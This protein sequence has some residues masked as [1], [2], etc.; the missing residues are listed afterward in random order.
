V[1]TFSSV[2]N[3][4]SIFPW[5]TGNG[6]LVWKAIGANNYVEL[7][8]AKRDVMTST[9][10]RTLFMVNAGATLSME[11]GGDV[12]WEGI[13]F[14]SP[15]KWTWEVSRATRM[16]VRECAFGGNS[17]SLPCACRL[18]TLYYWALA[19]V[20][21]SAHHTSQLNLTNVVVS[22]G[23]TDKTF[24]LMATNAARIN[25][26]NVLLE[27]NVNLDALQVSPCHLQLT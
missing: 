24:E 4:L 15:G 20:T 11:S 1:D 6:T 5:S 16:W 25:S 3:S 26:S 14:E 7:E 22:P 21:M 27:S 18:L 17:F 12:E 2:V 13:R 19:S 10:T 8:S 9:E 23:G